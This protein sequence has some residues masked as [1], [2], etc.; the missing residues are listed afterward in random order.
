MGDIGVILEAMESHDAS[1]Q[2]SAQND[3][4]STPSKPTAKGSRS[5]HL[6]HRQRLKV[7]N[8]EKTRQSA[9]TANADFVKNPF[10][11]IRRHLESSV[12]K[13]GHA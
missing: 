11:A 10:A 3:D 12:P 4:E 2:T 5:T 13:K 1:L 6:S 9:I 8:S 7:L